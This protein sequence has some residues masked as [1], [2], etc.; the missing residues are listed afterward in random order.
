MFELPFANKSQRM[1]MRP[2]VYMH[3]LCNPMLSKL[4]C[5]F[6]IENTTVF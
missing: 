4:R 6:M 3:R 5:E 2:Q 1:Y